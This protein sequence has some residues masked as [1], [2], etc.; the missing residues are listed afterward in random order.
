[1][2]PGS[3]AVF[4]FISGI[5]I[6]L[7]SLSTIGDE[8]D[9]KADPYVRFMLLGTSLMIMAIGIKVIFNVNTSVAILE[10]LFRI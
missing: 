4:L 7:Y 10:N 1:M 5:G 3:L 2:Y 6:F 8:L 9:G